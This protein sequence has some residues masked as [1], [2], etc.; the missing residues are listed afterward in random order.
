MLKEYNTY[1]SEIADDVKTTN[2]YAMTGDGILLG[3]TV[4]QHLQEW[5]LLK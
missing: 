3:K 2:S 1:W 4:V 5:A